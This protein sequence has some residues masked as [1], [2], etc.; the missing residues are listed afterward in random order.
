VPRDTQIL[1][2][3][4][5]DAPKDYTIDQN[6]ELILR[7]VHAQFRDNGAGGDWLPC[8]DLISDSG[9]T[10]ARCTDPAALV[11][12]GDDAEVTWFPDVKPAAAAAPSGTGL[13]FA[14]AWNDSFSGDTA[15][16]VLAG[17][18]TSAEFAHTETTASS[19]IS[20]STTT[21]TNDTA[22]LNVPGTYLL[23]VGSQWSVGG[24]DMTSEI[25]AF[26]GS[27][28]SFPHLPFTPLGNPL[29]FDGIGNA[30]SQD[31]AVFHDSSHAGTERI[32][33]SNRSGADHLVTSC[34]FVIVYLGTG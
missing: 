9:H 11:T 12:A 34:Y 13:A 10:I 32:L 21:H 25:N 29:I 31:F 22:N 28:N 3:P 8:V 23:F 24:D 33:V 16:N 15:Q 1:L 26:A 5:T 18:A 2:A 27:T 17:T 20:F 14:R 30:S 6:V 7:S 4:P 19:I